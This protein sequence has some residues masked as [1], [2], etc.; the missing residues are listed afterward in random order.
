M[1][2]FKWVLRRPDLHTYHE[3]ISHRLAAAIWET[4]DRLW[5]ADLY[6]MDMGFHILKGFATMGDA[7]AAVEAIVPIYWSRDE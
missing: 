7:K 4:V 5:C 1:A 6:N 2:K 3:A